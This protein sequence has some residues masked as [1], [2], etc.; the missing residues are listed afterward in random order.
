[1]GVFVYVLPITTQ[2]ALSG[3]LRA[4]L[5]V[6]RVLGIALTVLILTALAGVVAIVPDHITR[7]EA[8]RYGVGV[9]AIIKA[10]TASGA[11]ALRPP[12]E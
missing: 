10:L 12:R 8:I 4:G 5:T 3:R 9:Q 2:L 1:M 6:A 7:G 11:E